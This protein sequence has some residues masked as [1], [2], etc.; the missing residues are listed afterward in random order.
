MHVF[1]APAASK[2]SIVE[3]QASE[4]KMYVFK[5]ASNKR[6]PAMSNPPTNVVKPA[7][8]DN[9]QTIP[10][11][12]RKAEVYLKTGYRRDDLDWSVASSVGTPNIL[13]ELQ[14]RDIE[15]ATVTVGSD[16]YWGEQWITNLEFSYGRIFDG[17]NQDS[18]YLGNN[19]TLEF[20]RSNNAADEG[21]AYD[22]N[23][24]LAYRLAFDS[25]RS[26]ELRPTLGLS[27]HAQNLKAVDGYQTVTDFGFPV[28]IG[29]FEGLNSSYDATW[30]GPW[31]GMQALFGQESRLQLELGLQYH[32]AFYDAQANWN[33]RSD[34]AHPVSFEQ[35]AEGHGWVVEAGLL[36]E[37]SSKLSVGFDFRYE[38]WGRT[39]MAKTKSTFL[40]A[41]NNLL[42][43]LTM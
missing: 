27:Y 28:P 29:P 15:M 10:A 1:D 7:A 39:V 2:S 19:R 18:D 3:S 11:L 4:L 41:A 40:T 31:L 26:I 12:Y 16:L 6:V 14:W 37:L 32:Y 23:A 34:F 5:H 25:M 20:S 8:V 35:E 9:Q 13:S 42:T 38:D 21:D 30:F 33:L 24:S 36:Y 22:I 17:E 43:G